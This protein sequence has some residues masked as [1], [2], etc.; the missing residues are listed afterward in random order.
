MLPGSGGRT[1]N[2]LGW[3]IGR[4]LTGR[5]MYDRE[6]NDLRARR[7]LPSVTSNVA[8]G[9]ERAGRT[10][11]LT[12]RHYWPAPSDWP[13]EVVQTGFTV[14]DGGRAALSEDLAAYLDDGPPPVLVTFGTSAATAAGASFT[15][16]ARSIQSAAAHPGGRSG[17]GG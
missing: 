10:L 3:R 11:L 12:S 5:M 17:H 6:I 2:G 1:L 4:S 15:Q 7:A 13:G 9:W 8:F 16:V 14:W